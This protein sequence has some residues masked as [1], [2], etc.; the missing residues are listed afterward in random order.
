LPGL[1]VEPGILWLSYHGG[2]PFFPLPYIQAGLDLAV[3]GCQMVYFQTKN[4]DSDI[5][6][7]ALKWKM[8]VYFMT[9]WHI[10][11]TFDIFYEHLVC[12]VVFG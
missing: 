8:L 9:S 7:R 3:Q 11:W 4:Y 2:S 1:G 10:L 6:S 5:F 12:F